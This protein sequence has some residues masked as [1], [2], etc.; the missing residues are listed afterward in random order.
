MENRDHMLL[1]SSISLKAIAWRICL[2]FCSFI[3]LKKYIKN[4]RIDSGKTKIIR[5]AYHS[6]GNFTEINNFNK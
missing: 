6:N 3:L 2:Y 4:R 1:S 5:N